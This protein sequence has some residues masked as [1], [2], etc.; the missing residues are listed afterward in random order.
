M[1]RDVLFRNLPNVLAGH[2]HDGDVPPVA[3]LL[4][5]SLLRQGHAI[6]AHAHN[7]P[8]VDGNQF[9]V[10]LLDLRGS[11][12]PLKI[13]R[14][15]LFGFIQPVDFHY[16]FLFERFASAVANTQVSIPLQSIQGETIFR[17]RRNQNQRSLAP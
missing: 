11:Q 4:L 17:R 12:G 10:V 1:R 13:V 7:T 3:L 5:G 6:R 16:A 8:F 14:H 9:A 15:L 2:G